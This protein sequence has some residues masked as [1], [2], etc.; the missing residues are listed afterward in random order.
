M[1]VTP[2][3]AATDVL[4]RANT[5][6]SLDVEPAPDGARQD[7][8]RAAFVMSV[9]AIDTQLHWLVR[10]VPLAGTLPKTLAKMEVP[11]QSLVDMA[12]R[13]VENR[14]RGIADRPE[15]RARNVLNE[16]ILKMP[17]QGA[18]AVERALGM[19]GIAHVWTKLG[20]AMSPAETGNDVK[21]QLNKLTHRRNQ[22]AHEGDL[23]RLVRPQAVTHQDISAESVAEALAWARRFCAAIHTVSS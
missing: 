21:D 12:E 22:I 13:S 10:R 23:R 2:Y 9:T 11:L 4:D 15:T 7:I 14:R 20:A 3:Q 19:A 5:L 17:F 16:T 8:R 1:P 6:L 18:S